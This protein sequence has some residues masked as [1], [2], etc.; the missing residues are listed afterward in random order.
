MQFSLCDNTPKV[1]LFHSLHY[2]KKKLQ[3]FFLASQNT[4][5]FSDE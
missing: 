4:I 5:V 3:T 1:V 2:Y